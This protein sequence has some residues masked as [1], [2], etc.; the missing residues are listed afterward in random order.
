MGVYDPITTHRELLA[1]EL[2][3]TCN[4]PLAAH[5]WWGVG[6]PADLFCQV[7]TREQLIRAITIAHENSAP[8][9]VLGAGS[10]ILVSDTGVDGLVLQLSGDLCDAIRDGDQLTAGAGLRLNVLL[11]RAKKFDWP[12]LHLFAGIPGTIGGA[13]KMNAGASLGVT[14]D[15]LLHARV[16][17]ADGTVET[18][19]AQQLQMRYRLTNLPVGAVIMD[20]TFSLSGTTTE[21]AA[22][23]QKHLVHRAETQPLAERTVGSTFRNPDGDFAG[24]LIE[25]TGLKGLTIGGASVSHKHANFVVNDGTATAHELRELIFEVRRRVEEAT[26]IRLVP[27]VHFVGRWLR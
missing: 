17:L 1:A 27:E 16:V 11:N 9:F 23:I 12:G 13:V 21:S 10:N 8:T 2:T 4:H 22:L 20:A 19:S 6:G 14:A 18:Y 25:S 15:I 24:R 26:G 7:H 5:A 3:A